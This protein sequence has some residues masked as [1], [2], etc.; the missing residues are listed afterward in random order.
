MGRAER[1]GAPEPISAWGRTA[2]HIPVG[3]YGRA[4]DIAAAVRFFCLPEAEFTSG[5]SLLVD[6]AH[7]TRL[8]E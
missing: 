6:G 3:R 4:E 5:Q 7:G 2:D 8:H 1:P